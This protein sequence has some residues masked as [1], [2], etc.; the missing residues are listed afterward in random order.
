MSHCVIKLKRELKLKEKTQ[1]ERKRQ[2]KKN[3]LQE[4]MEIST[5][6]AGQNAV[7]N[8]RIQNAA[9]V[10]IYTPTINETTE[11]KSRVNSI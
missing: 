7:K 4:T 11:K 6:V 1:K 10:E 2:G 9:K 5:K 3:Q 8:Y